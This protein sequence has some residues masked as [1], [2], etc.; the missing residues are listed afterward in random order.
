MKSFDILIIGAGPAGMSAAAYAV[1]GNLKVGMIDR[2]APGGKVVKTATI[3]NFIG[4]SNVVGPDLAY[5]MYEHTINLGISYIYGDVQDIK[6]DE[7]GDYIVDAGDEDK[8]FKAKVVII[9]TGTIERK[10]GIPNEVEFYGRGVSYCAICD[11]ALYKNKPVA[12]IG[13][14]NSACEEAVYLT[15]F[16]S[17]VYLVHRRYE[18][19]A[20]KVAVEELMENKK[21]K[22]FLNYLPTEVLTNGQVVNGLEIKS[23]ETNKPEKLIVDCVFPFIGQDPVTNFVESF[24]VLDEEKYIPVDD[25]MKTTHPGIFACGDIITKNIRQIANAVG[26]GAIAG[27][28][29]TYYCYELAKAKAK[30]HKPSW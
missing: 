11:A 28:N 29:A 16:C 10:I 4:Y 24:N 22:T 18:F 3:D 17:I 8:Q 12:V 1:R 25:H 5:K 23:K 26:E 27:Q 15:K 2:G 13:G 21:I 30:N 6:Q 14:G 7:S 9:A 20:T 19:R